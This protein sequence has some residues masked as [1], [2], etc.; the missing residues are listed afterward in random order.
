[1]PPTIL[2]QEALSPQHAFVVQFRVSSDLARRQYHGRVEHVMSG[3]AALFASLDELA[4]FMT[5]VVTDLQHLP[6]EEKKCTCA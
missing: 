5:R 6:A 4:T 3:R 2:A 1:M